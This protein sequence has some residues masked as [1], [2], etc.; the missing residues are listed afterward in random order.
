MISPAKEALGRVHANHSTG[1]ASNLRGRVSQEIDNAVTSAG[2]V[3]TGVG[4]ML[5]TLGGIVARRSLRINEGPPGGLKY[6]SPSPE[7]DNL[8]RRA[9]SPALHAFSKQET[10]QRSRSEVDSNLW[11][12][13]SSPKSNNQG[14][15]GNSKSSPSTSK[16]NSIIVREKDDPSNVVASSNDSSRLNVPVHSRLGGGNGDK[17]VTPPAQQQPPFVRDK[18]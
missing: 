1:P 5:D 18:Y 6:S 11:E 7:R 2:K 16:R 9:S 4:G 17:P 8:A 13:G 15:D 12:E 14:R 10:R 3:L